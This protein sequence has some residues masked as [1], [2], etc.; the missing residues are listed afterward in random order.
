MISNGI[1]SHY[2]GMEV[3]LRFVDGGHALGRVEKL[4]SDFLL[5]HSDAGGEEKIPLEKIKYI[6]M[7]PLGHKEFEGAARTRIDDLIK[8]GKAKNENDAIEMLK[9][10]FRK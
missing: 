1:L 6:E 10:E 8:R 5:L 3:A 7:K 2:V 9:K 4:G